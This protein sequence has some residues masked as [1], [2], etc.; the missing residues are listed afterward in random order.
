MIKSF[1]CKETQAVFEGREPRRFKAIGSVAERKLQMLDVAKT[2][3]DL[4]CP[5]GNRLEAL[6]GGR[7]GQWSIRINEQWRLCFCFADGEATE[8]EI[9]DYH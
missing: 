3:E 5:P 2:I 9:V 8:V 1:R 6:K 4:R 7:R